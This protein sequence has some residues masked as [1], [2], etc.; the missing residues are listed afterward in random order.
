MSPNINTAFKVGSSL[1]LIERLRSPLHGKFQSQPCLKTTLNSSDRLSFTEGGP[2]PTSQKCHMFGIDCRI[3]SLDI[4]REIEQ[5]SKEREAVLQS[6]NCSQL[7]ESE[8]V[9]KHEGDVQL[10]SRQEVWEKTAAPISPYRSVTAE[11]VYPDDLKVLVNESDD[12]SRLQE[13]EEI[14][15]AYFQSSNPPQVKPSLYTAGSREVES[16]HNSELNDS[17]MENPLLAR[18]TAYPSCN[19]TLEGK[20][21]VCSNRAKAHMLYIDQETITKIHR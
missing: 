14:R 1:E 2:C 8:A 12:V 4:W 7:L 19:L 6:L 9:S 21:Q 5:R 11:H 16:E 3:S 15:T 20:R 17:C 18:A 13:L 10:F